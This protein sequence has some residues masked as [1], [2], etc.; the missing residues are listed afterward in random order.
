VTTIVVALVCTALGWAL[1]RWHLVRQNAGEAAVRRTLSLH[2]PSPA[3]HLLNDLT[4]PTDDGTTQVDHILV[5]RYGVFVLETKHYKGWIFGNAGASQWTQVLYKKHYKFQ[6]PI[7][8]NLKH[9]TVVR[10]LLD[11]LPPDCIHSI[12]VFTGEAVFKTEQPP[13]VLTLD[14]LCAHLDTFNLEAMT[15]NRVH[16]SVGRLE[17]WRK[18]ITRETDVE[19]VAHL[20]RK[21]GDSL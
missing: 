4:L 1:G 16:F 21:F 3:Y 14:Q 10:R 13:G 5:S 7:H 11:F 17:C 20:K 18:A 8:Q 12:V 2:F 6:N 9:V 19:H 15:E